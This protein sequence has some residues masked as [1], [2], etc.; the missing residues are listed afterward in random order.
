[1]RRDAALK[2]LFILEKSDTVPSKVRFERNKC[3]SNLRFDFLDGLW[4]G[5]PIGERYAAT[6]VNLHLHRR[7]SGDRMRY[8]T[9][10]S[11]TA[12]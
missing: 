6:G 3:I 4:N 7:L 8:L 12:G 9:V 1:V 11:P 10:V 5:R 2:M